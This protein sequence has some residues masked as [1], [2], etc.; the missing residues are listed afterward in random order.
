MREIAIHYTCARWPRALVL[1]GRARA[2]MCCRPRITSKT[3]S[4]LGTYLLLLARGVI[5]VPAAV[6]RQC[7]FVCLLALTKL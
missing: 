5:W 7:R 3:V 6:F 4:V 2:H 1:A